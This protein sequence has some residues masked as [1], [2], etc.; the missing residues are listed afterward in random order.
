MKNVTNNSSIGMVRAGRLIL[1][2]LILFFL[3][4][5]LSTGLSCSGKEEP[6]KVVLE[7]ISSPV[8]VSGSGG[9]F[10][11]TNSKVLRCISLEEKSDRIAAVISKAKSDKIKA[12]IFVNSA[13]LEACESC[14]ARIAYVNLEKGESEYDMSGAFYRTVSFSSAIESVNLGGLPYADWLTGTLSQDE[15]FPCCQ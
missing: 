11:E 4:A 5:G 12:L 1:S 9:T 14:P 2:L 7:L 10:D 15:L 6:T 13:D 8:A 3:L